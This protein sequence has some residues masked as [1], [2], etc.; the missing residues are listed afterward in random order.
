MLF[1]SDEEEITDDDN[2]KYINKNNLL[3]NTSDLS[4]SEEEK[5]ETRGQ[6]RNFKKFDASNSDRTHSRNRKF[7]R[8]NIPNYHELIKENS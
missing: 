1:V 6:K 3:F 4:D 5:E 7:R 8:L 2:T